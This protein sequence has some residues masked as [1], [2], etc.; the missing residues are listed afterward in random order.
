MLFTPIGAVIVAII[1]VAVVLAIRGGRF[2][3]R[4][5]SGKTTKEIQFV[6]GQRDD[7]NDK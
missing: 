4:P 3:A 7:R 1:A 6:A 2:H 5:Q